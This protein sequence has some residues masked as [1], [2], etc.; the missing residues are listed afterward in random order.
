M[1]HQWP[2]SQSTGETRPWVGAARAAAHMTQ[3]AD[4]GKDET[5]KS[6]LTCCCSSPSS[7]DQIRRNITRKT[8]GPSHPLDWHD[9]AG[10][11]S[12]K[13]SQFYLWACNLVKWACMLDFIISA[14]NVTPI[15]IMPIY[16]MKAASVVLRI[17]NDWCIISKFNTINSPENQQYIS[18][19]WLISFSFAHIKVLTVDLWFCHM[20]QSSYY[21]R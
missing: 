18:W 1:S 15:S 12:V 7:T 9:W 2:S 14:I 10:A 20:T 13:S 17:S 16:S 5:T 21:G 8:S 11:N 3:C 6:R 4:G 19:K